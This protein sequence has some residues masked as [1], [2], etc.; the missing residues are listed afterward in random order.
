MNCPNC[1]SK[2]TAQ[3]LNRY[4]YIES[5]LSNIYLKSITQWLCHQCESEEVE[6]PDPS[7]LQDAIAR[8]LVSKERKL[9]GREF[10]FLRTYLG[11]SGAEIASRF[12]ISR[13]TISRWETG[14]LKPP[15]PADIA[16]RYMVLTGKAN[17]NY[18]VTDLNE[19]LE[20]RR[21][22]KLLEAQFQNEWKIENKA[23]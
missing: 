22:I 12:A 4:H 14:V 7:G 2:M 3:K 15:G 1:N 17:H 23:A 8:A 9:N 19:I 10:R 20:S 16:L 13:E 21:R 6:I 18:K 11:Y 5:G